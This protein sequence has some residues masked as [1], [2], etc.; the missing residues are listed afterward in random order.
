MRVCFNRSSHSTL[1]K[2]QG[3]PYLL[4]TIKYD[5]YILIYSVKFNNTIIIIKVNKFVSKLM[6]TCR[7]KQ[8]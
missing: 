7:I 6:L 5:K 4:C 2:I 3:F 8:R 1:K